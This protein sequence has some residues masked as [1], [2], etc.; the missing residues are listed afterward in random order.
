MYFKKNEESKFFGK[1]FGVVKVHVITLVLSKRRKK[2][3]G[4][5][6][7]TMVVHSWKRWE[8]FPTRFQLVQLCKMLPVD[9]M[10][11]FWSGTA[12]SFTMSYMMNV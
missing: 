12:V 8:I 6:C 1:V 7:T 2:T 11:W 3:D 5:Y 10:A 4:N 9:C